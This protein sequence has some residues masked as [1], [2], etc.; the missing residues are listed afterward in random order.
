MSTTLSPRLRIGYASGGIATGAFGTVPGLLLL[1]YLTDALGISALIAGLIVFLPKAWD[2]IL[3]PITGRISDRFASS[4]GN[5]R[6]FLL[7]G[8]VAL[9]LS[10]VLLFS[11]PHSPRPLAAAWVVILFVICATAYSIFQVPYVALPAE[12]TDSYPE[13]TRLLTWRVAILAL[14]ILISGA[15]APLIRNTVGGANGYRAMAAFVAGLILIGTVGVYLGTRGAHV[16]RTPLAEGG[17]MAQLQIAIAVKD[18]RRLLIT[19]MVQALGIGAMLAGVD[20]VARVVLG[21]PAAS[22]ILFGCFVGPALLFAPLWQRVAGRLG[23]QQGYQLSSVVLATGAISLIG[24][25]HVPVVI[26]YVLIG[27]TG[28]GYAGCQLFPLA[29]LPDTS[30]D[31]AQRTGENRIGVFTGVWTAGETLGL[32]L[33]PAVFALVLSVGGY[34]SSIDGAVSQP[35]SAVLAITWGFSLVPAALIVASLLSLRGYALTRE[36]VE[37]HGG[38]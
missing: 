7:W 27:I 18:F 11:G 10:F 4:R 29:M 30:A 1:P 20:Y 6:P 15:T 25:G 17:L 16:S 24:A 5:R 31:N 34:R 23:K 33:G 9:A 21:N 35:A 2:V 19:F 22:S 38:S 37:A 3:N 8:G 26:V 28:I 12:L 13:R 36:D 14:A 32:A